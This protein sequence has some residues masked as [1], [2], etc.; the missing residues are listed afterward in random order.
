MPEVDKR[1]LLD[2]EVF[3]YHASKQNKVFMRFLFEVQ[4]SNHSQESSTPSAKLLPP[5]IMMVV[6]NEVIAA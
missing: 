2:E 3:S 4:L 1:N 6:L 5:Q